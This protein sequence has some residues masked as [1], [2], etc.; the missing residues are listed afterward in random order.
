M[1]GLS[2]GNWVPNPSGENSP[3]SRDVGVPSSSD[4]GDNRAAHSSSE[5]WRDSSGSGTGDRCRGS[6]V[7]GSAAFDFFCRRA[8]RFSLRRS[9]NA[10]LAGMLALSILSFI[11]SATAAATAGGGDDVGR[12]GAA[13]AAG[14]VAAAGVGAGAGAGASWGGAAVRAAG[15]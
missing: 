12:G 15:A 11:S 5:G 9:G 10:C 13:V 4:E 1:V 2:V 7:L 3:D 6:G 14:A 8:R